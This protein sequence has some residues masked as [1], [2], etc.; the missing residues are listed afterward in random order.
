MSVAG[1]ER[2]AVVL[3]RLR[4]VES[5]RPAARSAQLD[6]LRALAVTSVVAYHA[7]FLVPRV[8]YRIFPLGLHLDVGVVVFFVLSGYLI[9]RPFVAA[10]LAGARGPA[11]GRYLLRR[12]ARIYPAYVAALLGL[13]ALGWIHF[14][15]RWQF[16]Q[17]VTLTQGYFPRAGTDLLVRPGIAQSWTLVVEVSFYLFV[18]VWAAVM[19][20]AHGRRLGDTFR[21]E[22]AGAAGL[23]VV[24]V[25][26]NAWAAY[27]GLPVGLAVLPPH[28]PALG[29]G[30][31]L[32]IL[33][34]AREQGER[35][36]EGRPVTELCWLG[37]LGA[38][39][40]LTLLV[41]EVAGSS[42]DMLIDA[43]LSL[44]VAVLV[45]TPV[46]LRA[47]T[48]GLVGRLLAW[49]PVATLG[50]ISFGVY[51]WHEDVLMDLPGPWQAEPLPQAVAGIA[52]RVA[53]GV[54]IAAVSY[55]VLER[56]ALRR[57]PSR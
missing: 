17:H 48:L 34:G 25:A 51:L 45:V 29:W 49:R 16:V 6:G 24:G 41:D 18:P 39:A 21:V 53:V 11:L 12:A 27:R 35:E 22:L 54:A 55:V 32:A 47:P 20:W 40:L 8:W 28:L 14:D 3:P 1:G 36:P 43:G 37:A 7:C 4:S 9:Y 50:L 56:P 46:V 42:A 33:V 57:V 5:R 26:A 19:A 2:A 52:A 31:T 44:A 30:M 13:L 38:L 10:H 23:M 15:D